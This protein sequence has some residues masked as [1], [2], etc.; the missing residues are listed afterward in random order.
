MVSRENKVVLICIVLAISLLFGLLSVSDPP[1]WVSGAVILGF[2]VI[3]P[4]LVNGLL[5]RRE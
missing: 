5:D 3:A 4:L 2:G 1:T